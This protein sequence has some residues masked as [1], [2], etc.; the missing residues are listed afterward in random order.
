MR[1]FL[2][3]L[4]AIQ[5]VGMFVSAI[6]SMIEIE[7]IMATGPVLAVTGLMIAACSF[8]ADYELGFFYGLAVLGVAVLCF[9][10][11]FGLEWGP[12]DAAV[13][14]ASLLFLAAFGSAPLG[15]LAH[16]ELRRSVL[17]KLSVCPQS[18]LS[19]VVVLMFLISIGFGLALAAGNVGVAISVFLTYL[20]LVSCAAAAYHNRR[21]TLRAHIN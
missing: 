5:V 21:T 14:I 16:W 18:G 9:V 4:I 1:R 3:W 7:S 8:R 20:V 17:G 19:V 6:A 12:G 13:P 11:I 10:L 2:Q 15:L